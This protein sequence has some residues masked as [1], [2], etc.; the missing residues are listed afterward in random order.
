[1]TKSEKEQSISINDDKGPDNNSIWDFWAPIFMS[2]AL[3]SGIRHF[4]AEARYIP[5]GSMLPSLQIEDRILIEKFTLARRPPERGEIVVFKSPFSFDPIL[6]DNNSPSFLQCAIVN[7]PLVSFLTRLNHPACDAYIKRVVAI[8]GDKVV[9][10]SFGEVLINN[11][12]MYEPYVSKLCIMPNSDVGSCKELMVEVPSDHVLVLG[13][14]R[15]NSWDG[16]FWPGG[17]FLP[18]KE[19]IGRAVWRFWPFNRVGLLHQ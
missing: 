4:V 7:F 9:V 10:N 17:A 6:N 16:R 5:S 3:Y 15:Q 2:I 11:S 18:E 1:M 13:D 12:K 14:N 19:I 8:A